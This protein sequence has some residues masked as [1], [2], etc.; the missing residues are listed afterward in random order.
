MILISSIIIS[1]F[2]GPPIFKW[3]LNYLKE[4]NMISA[5]M[6][7]HGVVLKTCGTILSIAN[8]ITSD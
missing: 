3:A 5:L 8:K 2:V 6:S 1:Q 4:T 7:L